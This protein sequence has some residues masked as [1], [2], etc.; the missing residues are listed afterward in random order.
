MWEY[1]GNRTDNGIAS[2]GCDS[3]LIVAMNDKIEVYEVN[4]G[5][6]QGDELLLLRKSITVEEGAK[7]VRDTTHRDAYINENIAWGP[8]FTHFIVGI[9]VK[10]VFTSSRKSQTM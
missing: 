6:E 5:A 1:D 3:H 2:I 8:D 10:Y 4:N 9:I 7:A